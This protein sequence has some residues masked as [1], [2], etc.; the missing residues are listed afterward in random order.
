MNYNLV[1]RTSPVTV[2]L[3][4]MYQEPSSF[5]VPSRL[6]VLSLE[7]ME[8][9]CSNFAPK[10]ALIIGGLLSTTKDGLTT[11]DRLDLM[12]DAMPV[13]EASLAISICMARISAEVVIDRY[14]TDYVHDIARIV[15]TV[16]KEK[17]VT[18]NY[19][20]SPLTAASQIQ[21]LGTPAT[22]LYSSR[23]TDNL[24]EGI[25]RDQQM[26]NLN[27]LVESALDTDKA[28]DIMIGEMDGF[29]GDQQKYRQQVVALI[30][31]LRELLAED[32]GDLQGE[33]ILLSAVEEL[34][35]KESAE[36][37]TKS[38]YTDG[39]YDLTILDIVAAD[40]NS[41][42][43]KLRNMKL[44][45]LIGAN[46]VP[47]RVAT[48]V[49][50][51]LASKGLASELVETHDNK[52]LIEYLEKNTS[53]F[54]TIAGELTALIGRRI[55]IEDLKN[56]LQ[57]DSE[58]SIQEVLKIGDAFMK[59]HEPAQQSSA[60]GG[61]AFDSKKSGKQSINVGHRPVATQA[62]KRNRPP[63]SHPVAPIQTGASKDNGVQ[64]PTPA[65]APQPAQTDAVKE[66]EAVAA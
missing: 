43:G 1:N 20:S 17:Q 15:E 50:M 28:V 16:F 27:L 57:N 11:F 29:K 12:S 33:G 34:L 52:L 5:K 8:F 45:D 53:D 60:A 23:S 6:T 4:M 59:A 19:G 65:P 48:H 10:A 3:N 39:N 61:T 49:R 38:A 2:Q 21:N 46:N 55:S 14:A 37:L 64:K 66:G 36:R 47:T 26:S 35:S 40:K 58:I 24:I 62:L 30:Q 42:L 31:K 44:R 25:D 63:V 54:D 7:M 9:F 22:A 56:V 51:M 13:T 18:F 32:G 41:N